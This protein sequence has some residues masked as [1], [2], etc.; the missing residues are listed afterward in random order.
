MIHNNAFT[1][2]NITD[3][4]QTSN[5]S[6]ICLSPDKKIDV[7]FVHP[8]SY[9]PPANG[10]YTA[11]LNDTALNNLTDKVAIDRI[12]KIFEDDCNLFAPRYQQ[13]NIEVLAM[14]KEEADKHFIIPQN[15]I[16]AAFTYYLNNLNNGRPY[17][18]ASHS[19]GSDLLSNIIIE[20][21]SIIDINKIVAAYMPGWTFT[22]DFLK[23]T[24]FKLCSTPDE[25]GC[26]IVWNTI[27]ENG[28]SPTLLPGALCVNPLSWNSDNKKYSKS[29]N[30][31]AVILLKDGNEITV[32][33]FTSA[34][35]NNYGGLEVA[36]PQNVY[37]NLKMPMGPNCF[38]SY[39]Y[40][41]FFYNVKE[42][43]HLRC[44]SYLQKQ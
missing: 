26:L 37:D 21:P 41:F 4:S 28:T 20:N 35:I 18:I 1:Q 16:L 14:E 15:D 3:Y 12:L 29:D 36:I 27:A 11:D 30:K 5:W 17:I 19:Q 7:F 10:K 8:T 32:D 34:Q 44:K 13:A 2:D 43:V 24:N 9:G 22:E 33:N 31:G 6:E 38:H 40:D 23:K 25:S 42:N 39:D